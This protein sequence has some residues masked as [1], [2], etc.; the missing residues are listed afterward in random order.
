MKPQNQIT[1]AHKALLKQ[2]KNPFPAKFVKWRV[3][4][5][6]AD[7]TKG[8][9]LAYIDS[10]EVMKRFDEVC[11][12]A[13]WRDRLAEVKDGFIA[14]IDVK[15]DGEWI[16]RANAAGNTNVEPIKGGASDALKR[17]AATWGVG[18]YLYYLPNVWVA[19]KPQGKSYVLAEVPEL[20]DWA[21]PGQVED[22]QDIAEMEAQ[23]NSGADDL[24]I[25]IVID[26]VDKVRAAKSLEALDEVVESLQ[27]DERVVLANQ[28]SAKK[29]E[30]KHEADIHTDS[31]ERATA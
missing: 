13:G 1:D 4:A 11:G 10:R 27:P 15:I 16:T 24:D 5:T 21:L 25:D 28:I 14:E 20:P 18:R 6:N 23:I 31:G 22:W 17:A 19:I 8:I 7:K 29:R 12:I 9:A 3:G 26:N 2:L 30:L